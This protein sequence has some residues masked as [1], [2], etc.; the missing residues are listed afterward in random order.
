[1]RTSSIMKSQG[2]L[3]SFYSN[4]DPNL[5]LDGKYILFGV[6]KVI[7]VILHFLFVFNLLL[8]PNERITFLRSD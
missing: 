8:Y 5:L 2:I 4:F 7:F 6:S 3:E 1:M